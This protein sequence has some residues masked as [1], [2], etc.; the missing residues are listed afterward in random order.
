[1]IPAAMTAPE[2]DVAEVD[3]SHARVD[4]GHVDR[5]EVDQLQT[6]HADQGE[7]ERVRVDQLLVGAPTACGTAPS[8]STTS[9]SRTN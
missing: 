4:V 8:P 3:F 2:A 5:V 6:R 1:M 9:P 7:L